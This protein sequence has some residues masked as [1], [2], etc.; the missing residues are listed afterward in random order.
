MFWKFQACNENNIE[1]C[2]IDTHN[3]KYLKKE[4]DNK[5]MN[6]ITNIIDSKIGGRSGI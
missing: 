5:F 3:V 1:L 4:R 2:I 6:I